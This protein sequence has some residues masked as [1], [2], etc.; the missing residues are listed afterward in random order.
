M[1]RPIPIVNAS[2]EPR[3]HSSLLEEK[4]NINRTTAVIAAAAAAGIVGIIILGAMD[5]PA[6]VTKKTEI[7]KVVP[8]PSAA[9]KGTLDPHCTTEDVATHKMVVVSPGDRAVIGDSVRQCTA[10]GTWVIVGPAAVNR[11]TTT[12]VA[13]GKPVDVGVGDRAIVGDTLD[14]CTTNGWVAVGPAN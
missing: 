10:N 4:L 2:P 3:S 13:T 14:E 7:V 11:C 6:P 9:P 1:E 8:P 12:D 5:D